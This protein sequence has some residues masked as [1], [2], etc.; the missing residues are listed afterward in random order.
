MYIRIRIHFHTDSDTKPLTNDASSLPHSKQRHPCIRDDKAKDDD[1]GDYEEENDDDEYALRTDSASP[2]MPGRHATAPISG[3]RGQ[4]NGCTSSQPPP[5][6]AGGRFVD[7]SSSSSH[8]SSRDLEDPVYRLST[9]SHDPGPESEILMA[10][11]ADSC[12]SS[13]PDIGSPDR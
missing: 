10:E 3:G 5:P 7:H 11:K 2:V 4:S 12:Y 9:G 8:T 13:N 1:N 6:H